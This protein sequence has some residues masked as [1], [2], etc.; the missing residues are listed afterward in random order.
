MNNQDKEA[1]ENY[2]SLLGYSPYSEATL[3]L[4]NLVDGMICGGHQSNPSL[5]DISLSRSL[6]KVSPQRRL[7]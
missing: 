4:V 6:C 7:I 1:I 2:M 3:N 5:S